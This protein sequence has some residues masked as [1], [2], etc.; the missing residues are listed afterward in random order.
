[1]EKREKLIAQIESRLNLI[2]TISVLFST[3]LYSFFRFVGENETASNS[4]TLQAGSLAVAFIINYLVFALAK[5]RIAERWLW[6]LDLFLLATIACFILPLIVITSKQVKL[7]FYEG[8]GL[9]ASSYLTDAFAV[10]FAS[11]ALCVAIPW[12]TVWSGRKRQHHQ[13]KW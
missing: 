6:W 10:F 9:I 4:I 7:P 5:H 3:L 1:M 13:F 12:R 2:I 8:L 11:L